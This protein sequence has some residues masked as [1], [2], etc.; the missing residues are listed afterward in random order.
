MERT[1][2]ER[3]GVEPLY[4]SQVL[5]QHTLEKKMRTCLVGDVA[6]VDTLVNL[7][8]TPQ[9]DTDTFEHRMSLTRGQMTE[10]QRSMEEEV[11][12]SDLMEIEGYLTVLEQRCE[13]LGWLL[14]DQEVLHGMDLR[15]VER[16]REQ[17]RA[18]WERQMRERDEDLL[19]SL[20]TVA[21]SRE[22]VISDLRKRQGMGGAVR[23]LPAC[24]LPERIRRWFSSRLSCMNVRGRGSPSVNPSTCSGGRTAGSA[25]ISQLWN[26]AHRMYEV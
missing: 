10:T 11:E 9:T 26:N 19:A 15:A 13:N 16:E 24:S 7:I 8:S 3:E 20:M 18:E 2:G 12:V 17:E 25:G 4:Q 23:N 14:K 22:R 1:E 5:I 21:I 6:E